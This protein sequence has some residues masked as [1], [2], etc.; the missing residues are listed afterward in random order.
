MEQQKAIYHAV[1]SAYRAE[2]LA[3]RPGAAFSEIARSAE[4]VFAA[5]G[6]SGFS[7]HDYGHGIGLDLPEPPRIGIDDTATVQPGMVI[8]LHPS[9]RVPGIGGAFVGGTVLVHPDQTEE[10]HAIPAD[11]PEQ[12]A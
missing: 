3:C 7:E 11:L 10:I 1:H 12:A 9:L 2:V 5:R 4:N 8:V 6:F